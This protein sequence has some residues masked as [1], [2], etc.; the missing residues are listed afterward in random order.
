MR[1]PAPSSTSRARSAFRV[2]L[3]AWA[4]HSTQ[5]APFADHRR[6]DSAPRDAVAARWR[7]IEVWHAS[8]VV[9]VHQ[10]Q[11][12]AD[13][14]PLR[15]ITLIHV[16]VLGLLIYEMPAHCKDVL[17]VAPGD[18]Q[19][20]ARFDALSANVQLDGGRTRERLDEKWASTASTC[21]PVACRIAKS[22]NLECLL[23]RS[24][25]ST[26]DPNARE[27]MRQLGPLRV[28]GKQRVRPLSRARLDLIPVGFPL[29]EV[30]VHVRNA[31]RRGERLR[32][33]RGAV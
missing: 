27:R 31:F 11:M 18:V 21:S 20:A 10:L 33:A 9:K 3:A 28:D 32:R 24:G 30:D 5:E 25:A 6:R 8:A 23:L 17:P 22:T 12:V 19:K 16:L 26:N 1:V 2:G 14:E 13:R 29:L 7:G 15:S 4:A